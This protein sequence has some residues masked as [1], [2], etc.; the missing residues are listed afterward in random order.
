MKRDREALYWQMLGAMGSQGQAG[1][2]RADA[3]M[4]DAQKLRR[5]WA[6]SREN[7]IKEDG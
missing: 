4:W 3:A 2:T 7:Y 1:A 5:I 6:N